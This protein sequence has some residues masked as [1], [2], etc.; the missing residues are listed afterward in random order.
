VSAAILK[1][2][3]GEKIYKDHGRDLAEVNVENIRLTTSTF[4]TFYA[5]GAF[6]WRM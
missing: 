3:Y 2:A 1:I 6:P 4:T 5:V